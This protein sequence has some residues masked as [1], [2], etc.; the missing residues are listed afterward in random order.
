MGGPN[1]NK[2]FE[3]KLLN[4]LKEDKVHN[5]FFIKIK[6][7]IFDFDTFVVAIHSFF[8]LPSARREDYSNFVEIA[9]LIAQYVLEHSS[10]RWVT[11]KYVAV[12]LLEQWKN[13]KV[14]SSF[15]FYQ[16]REILKEKSKTLRDLRL[17]RKVFKMSMLKH[18]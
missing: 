15:F 14:F 2:A 7:L 8:E 1:V 3:D 6:E 11:L 17:L 12:G 9:D 4:C 5:V 18:I 13:L 10:A 16:N